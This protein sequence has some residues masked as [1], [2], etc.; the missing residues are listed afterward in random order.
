MTRTVKP[1]PVGALAPVQLRRRCEPASLGFETTAGL[2][3]IDLAVGQARALE[4]LQF[5]LGIDRSGFN[6]FVLGPAGIGKDSVLREVVGR[7]AARQP[8]ADDWCYVHNFREPNRPRVLRLPAGM[9]RRLADAVDR[10]L[11]ALLGAIP[12][13]FEQEGYR[14]RAEAIERDVKEREA[15]TINA[16]RVAAQQQGI[17]LIET[18]TSY[19]FAPVNAQAELLKPDE[20]QQ[21]PEARQQ[22]IRAA[23][24]A[25]H[26]EL[27]K[28]LRQF[29]LWR[30]ES[31][32]RLRA[33]NR[34]TAAAVVTQLLDELR[35]GYRDCPAALAHIEVLQEALIDH[36]TDFLPQGE[37][38]VQALFGHTGLPL[39]G[40]RFRINVLVSHAGTEGAPLIFE[41]LPHHANLVGRVEHQAHLGTLITDFGMIR[42][43]ALHRANGG[44]LV[45]D[46]LKLLTQPFAWE[47]LKRAL[48]AGAIAIEPLERTLSLISTSP[49][50]PEPIPLRLK[51]ILCGDRLLYYLLSLHDPEFQALF[52]VPADFED[53]LDRDET[54][55]VRFARL[56]GTLAR[57]D[58]LRAL[59]REA[60]ALVIE[61]SAR[62]IEDAEK[63]DGHLGRL[64]DLLKEADHWAGEAG[65]AV[66]GRV[67]VQTAIDRRARRA[68]R[69]RDEL[70][71]AIRRGT[72]LIDTRGRHIGQVNGLSV[73]RLGEYS[74]GH[75]VRITATTRLGSGKIVDIE[76]ETELGGALHSKGVMIL[77]A[78]LA[79]R[80]A[81]AQPLSLSAS[82]VFE[83][84]YGEVEG[85]SASLAEL[86][87]L[88]S[89]LA[90]LPVRQDIAVTG[91]V[92]QLGHV[93]PI[94][95]VNEKIEGFF[96]VCRAAGL[97]GGQGVMIPDANRPHLMLREDLVEAATAGRFHIYAVGTVDEA[98]AVLLDTAAGE[99]DEAGEFPVGTVN[100]RVEHT[101]RTWALLA[102]QMNQGGNGE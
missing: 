81:R 17:A 47:T 65:H 33:L 68:S 2:A 19:A 23:I 79:S 46:A 40:Q 7:L 101:L 45:L 76:R 31:Q 22:A 51:V 62:G 83:Q 48:R 52:K 36:A 98:L 55:Q 14:A 85:D 1:A 75:P 74:C 57:R 58:G 99:R 4:A 73:I 13:A 88:I 37:N 102:L 97:T 8:V 59:D 42:P 60:V 44:Y 39:P 54:G 24:D 61:Q 34:E 35:T 77:S 90:E 66:I 56:I 87:A 64:T 71:E 53:T 26:E 3:D 10:L 91:S 95:G 15:A 89:S 25:L 100:G 6:L 70:Y 92:N 18:P 78:L 67:A 20:F 72:L 69:I 41:A 86:C 9:G 49:L 28:Q 82:L 29:P 50:E 63:L 11:E 16:L 27:Q 96:D 94:G 84:S 80:Y 38:S 43:G 93:Q 21:L 12:A 5:G 30:R 32:E